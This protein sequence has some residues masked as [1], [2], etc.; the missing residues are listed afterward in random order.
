MCAVRWSHISGSLFEKSCPN[1][2]SLSLIGFNIT[3]VDAYMFLMVWLFWFPGVSSILF[4]GAIYI[5]VLQKLRDAFNLFFFQGLR[6][7]KYID[8]SRTPGMDGRFLRFVMKS[9]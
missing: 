8:L 2:T 3:D 4:F 9:Y 5:N 7:L 6:K 1:L